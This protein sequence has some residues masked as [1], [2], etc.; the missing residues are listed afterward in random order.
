MTAWKDACASATA[1]KV[2]VPKGTFKL[3]GAT[4]QGPCKAPIEFNLEGT[5]Q[6][7]AVGGAGFKPGDTWVAFEH[8]DFL[9]VSGTGTF[10]G[11]GQSA[12]GQKCERD[13]YCGNLPMVRPITCFVEFQICYIYIYILITRSR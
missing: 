13:E 11:Q 4:L 5:L 9:T 3:S 12:W 1:S 10:D 8:V 2:V 7:P 6:A